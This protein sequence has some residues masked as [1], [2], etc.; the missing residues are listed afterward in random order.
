MKPKTIKLT[1]PKII[2]HAKDFKR[3]QEGFMKDMASLEAKHRK[4]VNDHVAAYKKEARRLF[5]LC[6]EDILDDPDDSFS[7]QRHQLNLDYVVDHGDVYLSE[8]PT[9]EPDKH[10]HDDDEE[11]DDREPPTRPVI[12]Q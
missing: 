3:A 11:D 2:A 8:L 6:P 10:Q 12:I 5:R 1:D 7:N 9:G 4:E